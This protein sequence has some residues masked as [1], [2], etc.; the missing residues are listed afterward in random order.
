MHLF[1]EATLADEDAVLDLARHL[2]TLNLPPEPAVIRDL[3]EASTRS[4][5]GRDA[6]DPTRRFVFVLETPDGDVVGTSMVHAQHGVFGDPH[7][8]FTVSVEERYAEFS[9]RADPPRVH[10]KHTMLQLGATYEG[11]TELGGLVLHPDV[12]SHPGRLG[13]LLS[14]G[15]FAFIAAFRSWVRDRLLAELLPPLYKGPSGTR[16]PLWDALG[17]HFTGLSY[18]EADKLSR[19]DKRFIWDLFPRMPVHASLLPASVQEILGRVG[20]ETKGAEKMLTSIGF[21][22]VDRIDPFDGGPHVEAQT[23]A[24]SL[25][26]DAVRATAEVGDPS[27]RGVPALV[28]VRDAAAPH[29]RAIWADVEAVG[30]RVRISQPALERL[31]VPNGGPVGIVLQPRRRAG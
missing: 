11:P 17:H 5:D 4:F 3:L 18:D 7:V 22:Y 20:P 2:D 12:R 30:D 23:D 31:G 29:F 15:R 9:G 13:R 14:L 26:R 16:S 25:V 10:M 21:E 27:D 1:R 28:S 6:F 19:V 8:Y 24:V